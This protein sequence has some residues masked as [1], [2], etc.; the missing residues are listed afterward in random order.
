MAMIKYPFLKKVSHPVS[1]EG[2]RFDDGCRPRLSH[3]D[4]HPHPGRRRR[5]RGTTTT[6]TRTSHGG[7]HSILAANTKTM[8]N[9]GHNHLLLL[10]LLV[11]NPGVP[12]HQQLLMDGQ[13]IPAEVRKVLVL[14]VGRE[15]R[16]AQVRHGL[17]DGGVVVGGQVAGAGAR[18]DVGDGADGGGGD[19]GRAREAGVAG[20]GERVRGGDHGLPG[21]LAGGC[22][23]VE[24]DE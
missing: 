15:R 13:L 14:A 23:K 5:R 17:E 2:T 11:L 18:A 4:L 1:P 24:N 12:G 19:G 20:G 7:G 16:R 3:H 8:T 9:A 10:L 6:T 22:G 21:P